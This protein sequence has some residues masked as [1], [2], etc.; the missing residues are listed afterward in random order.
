ML[1]IKQGNCEYQVFN[2]AFTHAELTSTHRAESFYNS[3]IVL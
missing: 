1:I 3:I 2:A